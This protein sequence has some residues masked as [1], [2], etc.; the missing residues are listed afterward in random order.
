MILEAGSVRD[1]VAR[2]AS[3]R[4]RRGL[5]AD[6]RAEIAPKREA[7]H[8]GVLVEIGERIDRRHGEAGSGRRFRGGTR[9][10][11]REEDVLWHELTTLPPD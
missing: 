2:D 4:A 6:R 10:D 11:S 8:A 5:R 9:R 3:R 1:R 7:A